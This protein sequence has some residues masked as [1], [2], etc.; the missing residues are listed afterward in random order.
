V[1][2]KV[3]GGEAGGGS[4][5]AFPGDL[6]PGSVPA[7]SCVEVVPEH[8]ATG[9]LIR[10]EVVPAVPPST[11]VGHGEVIPALPPPASAH[12]DGLAVP[13]SRPGL[14]EAQV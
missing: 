12:G 1:G 9:A 10:G 7:A 8:P 11:A 4:G 5:F 14:T 3:I 13:L 6:S 2:G